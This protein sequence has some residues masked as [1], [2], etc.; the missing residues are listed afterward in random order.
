[1][2][3]RNQKRTTHIYI[4]G[5]HFIISPRKTRNKNKA[6]TTKQNAF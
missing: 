1:M 5:G 3:A 6:K 2:Y 4:V